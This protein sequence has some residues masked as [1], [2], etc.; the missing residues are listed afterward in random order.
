MTLNKA[1]AAAVLT[2]ARR[3]AP[4]PLKVD[5]FSMGAV[6]GYSEQHTLLLMTTE[7]EVDT[8]LNVSIAMC[9][10]VLWFS[11][12]RRFAAVQLSQQ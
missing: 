10:M 8:F 2:P 11:W 1:E 5:G 4:L 3:S 12:H 7:E 9:S 6:M